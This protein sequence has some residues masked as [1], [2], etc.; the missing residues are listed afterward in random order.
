MEELMDH[1]QTNFLD[2]W[3]FRRGWFPSALLR[4]HGR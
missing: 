1:L 4:T 2:A 3:E